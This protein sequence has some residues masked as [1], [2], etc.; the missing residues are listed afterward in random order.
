MES[1]KRIFSRIDRFQQRHVWLSFPVSVIRK[2]SDDQGGTLAALIAY[3]GF[4]GVF[5]L[6][7]IFAA[8]LGFIFAGHPDIQRTVLQSVDQSF[9]A[10][11]GYVEKTFNGSNLALGIGLV[12]ALWA[13]LGVTMATERAMNA[14]WDIPMSERPNIW[15]SRLRGLL[16]LGILGVFFLASSALTAIRGGSGA[17]GVTGDV[18][19][20]L[21]TVALNL[22]LYGLAFLV[23]TNRQL[24]W[25]R[26]FPGA[27]V[28]ALGWTLLLNLGELYISHT[29]AHASRLYGS[30]G[31][32]IGLVAWIYLGA[33]LTI[34]AAEVNVVIAYRL[35]PRSLVGL[36]DT[37]ADRRAVL[38]QVEEAQRAVGEQISVS[39]TQVATTV[40]LA[41]HEAAPDADAPD[42]APDA[43]SDADAAPDADSAPDAAPA[44]EPEA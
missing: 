13:G 41:P 42:A 14:I 35:W 19:A 16:M 26:V 12:G 11:S 18:L 32:V 10:M 36:A 27:A 43:D 39:F 22:L 28:G 15:W 7:L 5:P 17:L 25:R 44:P 9:P 40:T 20:L 2:A 6:L 31:I 3:Y 21:G 29:I 34:Y 30:I 24:S 8:I 1:L 37:D 33:R 4:L 38:R 23:L